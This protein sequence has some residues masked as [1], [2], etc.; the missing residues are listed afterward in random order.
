MGNKNCTQVQGDLPWLVNGSLAPHLQRPLW[1]HLAECPA[2]RSDLIVW[3]RLATDVR[4]VTAD[5]PSDALAAM[6]QTIRRRTVKAQAT[7]QRQ[8]VGAVFPPLT[9]AGDVAR[10]A[11]ARAMRLSNASLSPFPRH[12][13]SEGG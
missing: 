2:C 1:Q 12:V 11:V 9:V 7:S 13:P 8:T 5:A 10:W 3:A 6:W 4:A